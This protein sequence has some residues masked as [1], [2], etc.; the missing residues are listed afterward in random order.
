MPP[1][2]ARSA[3]RTLIRNAHPTSVSF[4]PHS[5]PGPRRHSPLAHL[6]TGRGSRRVC[7]SSWRRDSWGRRHGGYGAPVVADS[8]P[9][10]APSRVPRTAPAARVPPPP[11]RAP[12]VPAPRVPAPRVPAPPDHAPRVLAPRVPEFVSPLPPRCSASRRPSLP[13][14]CTRRMC[15]EGRSRGS[16]ANTPT[17]RWSWRSRQTPARCAPGSGDPWRHCPAL[18]SRRRSLA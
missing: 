4:R 14:P 11:D 13:P 12:P 3:R 16:P 8:R 10:P 7:A 2:P 18:F 6:R 15:A 9:A 17:S 1:R 5:R